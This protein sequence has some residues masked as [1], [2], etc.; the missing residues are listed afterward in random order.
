MINDKIFILGWS[1]PVSAA[2]PWLI[3][4]YHGLTIVTVVFF[5]L[6]FFQH[7]GYVRNPCSLMEGRHR[8]F[9][10]KPQSSLTFRENANEYWLVDFA[11]G[12]STHQVFR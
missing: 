8:G 5:L 6:L 1:N 2:K 7:L 3:C 10:W 11:Y 4:G 9:I 12:A